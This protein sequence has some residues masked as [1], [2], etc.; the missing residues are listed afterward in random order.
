MTELADTRNLPAGIEPIWTSR[1][2]IGTSGL[3]TL[4]ARAAALALA[5]LTQLEG[6]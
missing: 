1:A 4:F 5:Q 2:D 3:P 6:A